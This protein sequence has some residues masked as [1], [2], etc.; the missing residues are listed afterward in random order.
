MVNNVVLVGRITHDLELRQGA[1]SEFLGFSL[2]VQRNFK[3]QDGT[4]D[5]DFINCVAFGRTATFMSTYLQ[6]GA[7]VSVEGRL[8]QR[9]YENS[10]GQTIN[11]IEVV[12]NNVQGLE[13]RKS[14]QDNGFT[15]QQKVQQ[16]PKEPSPFDFVETPQ[17][18]AGDIVV[19]DTDIPF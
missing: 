11:V 19:D 14:Q 8:Q 2:A 16:T 18:P 12:A 7:L 6:K 15:P 4:Y 5:T 3:K 13:S 10:Q 17:A 9:R 1:S